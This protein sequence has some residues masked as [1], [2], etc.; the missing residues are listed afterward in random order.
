MLLPQFSESDA[1]G[2]A[3]RGRGEIFSANMLRGEIVWKLLL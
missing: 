3:D 2:A 1:I